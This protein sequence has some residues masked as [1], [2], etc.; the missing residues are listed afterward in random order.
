MIV[1]PKHHFCIYI[2]KRS[3][4]NRLPIGNGLQ[5]DHNRTELYQLQQ[6]GG[7]DDYNNEGHESTDHLMD[8]QARKTNSTSFFRPLQKSD[9]SSEEGSESGSETKCKKKRKGGIKGV[10][11]SVQKQLG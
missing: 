1:L 11:S 9:L 3:Q 4:H 10:T 6:I 2:L 8:I 5:K 7:N